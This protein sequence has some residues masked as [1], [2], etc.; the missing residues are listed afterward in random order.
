MIEW[1]VWSVKIIEHFV[2]YI[3]VLIDKVKVGDERLAWDGEKNGD[4]IFFTPLKRVIKKLL[5]AM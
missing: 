2:M 3:I 1:V 5:I 4:D